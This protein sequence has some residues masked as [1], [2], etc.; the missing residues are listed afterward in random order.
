MGDESEIKS[1]A[2]SVFV[3]LVTSDV[4]CCSF[5]CN[6][7]LITFLRLHFS[8]ETYQDEIGIGEKSTSRSAAT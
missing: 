1:F 3:H 8:D 5:S 7:I 4:Q 2:S 6:E